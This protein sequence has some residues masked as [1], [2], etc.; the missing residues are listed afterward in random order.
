MRVVVQI[1]V[2]CAIEKN[3]STTEYH[4]YN[5]NFEQGVSSERLFKNIK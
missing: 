5:K 2:C 4:W 3:Q 1:R